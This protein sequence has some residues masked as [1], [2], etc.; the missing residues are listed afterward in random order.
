LGALF[1]LG[2]AVCAVAAE[3]TGSPDAERAMDLCLGAG[4]APDPGPVL[5]RGLALAEKAV[6]ANERDPVAH[7]AVF[8]NLGKKLQ[9]QRRSF[10]SLTG[11]R[12]L[13]REVN[14]ALELAPDYLGA[15]IGKGSLLMQ[16]PGF[17][18]GDPAAGER[19]LREA[20]AAHPDEVEPRLELA[21]GL[22]EN[23]KRDE[24]RKEAREALR[25]AEQKGK[26]DDVTEARALVAEVGG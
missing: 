2:L 14:R 12:R 19:L 9:R 16:L 18:G 21:R 1:A 6:A 26:S 17:L 10:S 15:Q 7:F 24:A 13:L 25:V 11:A 22:A 20:I 5:E 3:P 8:C 4:G 23:G